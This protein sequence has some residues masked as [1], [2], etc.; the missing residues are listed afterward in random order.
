MSDEKDLLARYLTKARTDLVAKLDGLDERQIR[1]PMTA[2]GTNLLGI[3]KHVASVELGYLGDVMGRPS[4]I[5][6]PWYDDGAPD[7]ADM[8]AT[9]QESREQI[10][11][12][13]RASVE[14]SNA[15]IAALD[16]DSPGLVPWWSPERRHVTLRTILI[17]MGFEVARHAG[18]AD[19]LRELIDSRAGNN[20]GNLVEQSAEDWAIYRAQLEAAAIEA[21]AI[22]AAAARAAKESS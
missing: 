15:T 6:L 7:N 3:L 20:D 10:L 12:L 19:I 9:P 2:T 17:H 14:V 8:W 21:A 4:G 13:F 5:D 18:H 16:L 11:E 22:E 1:W